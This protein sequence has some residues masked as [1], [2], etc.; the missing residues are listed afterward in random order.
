[1]LNALRKS[2]GTWVAKVLIGLL[3]LSFAVWGVNDFIGGINRTTVATVGETDVSA[4]RFD[5]ALSIEIS[6]LQRQIQQPVSLSQAVAFGLPNQVMS[7]LVSQAALDDVSTKLNLGVSDDKLRGDIVNNP[8]FRGPDGQFDRSFLQQ[9]LQSN[10]MTESEF[11]SDQRSFSERRQISEGVSGGVAVPDTLLQALHSYRAET[12]AIRT[13]TL[14]A[15]DLPSIPEASNSD[16]KTYFEA[17]TATYRAPEYRSVSLVHLTLADLIDADA[18]SDDDARRVYEEQEERF[19]QEEQR[20]IQQI[21]FPNKE[22]ADAAK[23]KLATGTSWE[24]LLSERNVSA[25]DIDLGLVVKEDMI[26]QIIADAVFGLN[27]GAISDV[28][29]GRF[30]PV[31][32][33]VA[34]IQE[35]TTKAF[36]EVSTDIKG[37]IARDEAIEQ[38]FNVRD[39]VEDGIAGGATLSEVARTNNLT[40]RAI[41]DVDRNGLDTNSTVIAD[42]PLSSDLIAGIYEGEVGLENP[43]LEGDNEFVWYE[44]SGVTPER[45]RTIDEVTDRLAAD[46]VSEETAKALDELASRIAGNL[47]SSVSFDALARSRVKVVDTINSITRV[48][49]TEGLT[50]ENLTAIFETDLNKFSSITP[51]DPSQRLVFQLTDTTVPAYFAEEETTQQIAQAAGPAI[52]NEI[53]QQYIAELQTNLGVTLNQALLTQ[54][55]S[56]Q[57]QAQN[58]YQ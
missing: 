34:E 57:G 54:M 49:R 3:I 33:L 42:L 38:I 46:W 55:L 37:E 15:S 24:A 31:L 4:Q 17:N 44:I 40:L 29:K 16:L 7:E 48:A 36:E 8:S 45:D 58:Q 9:I 39:A 11:I 27:Q 56:N 6:R 30:G 2:A 26:D 43:P 14:D 18:V 51:A 32:A 13:I 22:E 35:A 52:E 10:N 23:D 28:I 41:D 53:L 5:R 19:S 47:A 50:P 21:V 25:S 20:R 1:M 12:R